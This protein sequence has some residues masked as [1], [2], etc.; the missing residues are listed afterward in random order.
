MKVLN[1]NVSSP[2]DKKLFEFTHGLDVDK[3]LYKQEI[4]VQ[5]SWLS[6]LMKISILSDAEGNLVLSALNKAEKLM[7]SGDF[8]WRI[9][10][11]DIHMN[12]E[13]FVIEECGEVGKKIHSGRS[14]NDLIATTLR[15]Y[16]CD[17][18]KQSQDLV[19]NLGLEIKK[20]ALEW[21]DVV[22]PGMTHLQFGQPIRLGHI[23]SSHAYAL[24]RDQKRLQDSIT[25]CLSYCPLGA[26]AFAGTHLPIDLKAIADD[27]GFSNPLDHSYDAVGD[28]DFILDALNSFTLLSVHLARLSEE[29]M[30]WSST[31]VGVLQLPNE[32]ST[33]SSIMP[34]KRNPDVL[35]LVR[36]KMAR[37]MSYSQEG[38]MIVKAV[39]PSYGTDLH[40]LK[41]TFIL[42]FRELTNSLKILSPFISGLRCNT[43]VAESKL[44]RG[45][46]L[47][48]DVANKLCEEGLPFRDAYLKTAAFIKEGDEN[49]KQVHEL[50]REQM[51]FELSF[52]SAVEQRKNLGGTARE[53]AISAVEKLP[54]SSD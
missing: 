1:S 45:H 25:E 27:L 38:S 24:A 19:S 31:P 11:E 48:T 41:R 5:K 6:A 42:S 20:R 16:V 35:E 33:G 37:V 29:V 50:A 47:A 13:R 49:S 40:E 32:Y 10:D 46:I 2:S 14:R 9:E 18:I 51:G 54:F 26:A 52:L 43:S 3:L 21:M 44:A 39:V 22:V 23:L 17:C 30:F 7:L 12:L 8:E 34:N 36:A 15:L 53:S 28:R 4:K